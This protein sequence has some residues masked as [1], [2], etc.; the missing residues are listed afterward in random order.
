MWFCDDDK[1]TVSAVSRC[2]CC[3]DE[4][5]EVPPIY[6]LYGDGLPKEVIWDTIPVGY[7]FFKCRKP[8]NW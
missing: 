3:D 8:D 1:R 6:Y 5:C 2:S 4:E 7:P